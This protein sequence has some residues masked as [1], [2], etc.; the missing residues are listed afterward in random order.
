MIRSPLTTP[1]PLGIDATV[2]AGT[3]YP[4]VTIKAPL[5][6]EF[7]SIPEWTGEAAVDLSTLSATARTRIGPR[8]LLIY[9]EDLST[10]DQTR[11][12]NYLGA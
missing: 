8:G 6:P 7:Q 11:A 10:A 12:D 3:T 4:A 9:G 5:G 1:G 2:T